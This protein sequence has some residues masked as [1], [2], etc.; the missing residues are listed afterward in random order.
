M[1]GTHFWYPESTQGTWYNQFGM[2]SI[3]K[4]SLS[5]N[6]SP[7]VPKPP[8]KCFKKVGKTVRPIGA[9]KAIYYNPKLDFGKKNYSSPKFGSLFPSK[10]RVKVVHEI[11]GPGTYQLMNDGHWGKDSPRFSI[12]MSERP[13]Y[14]KNVQQRAEESPDP[15]FHFQDME[16]KTSV[17]HYRSSFPKL[18]EPCLGPGPGHYLNGEAKARTD[19]I[20]PPSLEDKGMSFSRSPRFKGRTRMHKTSAQLRLEKEKCDYVQNNLENV[21]TKADK[22]E[23]IRKNSSARE[24]KLS[25]AEQNR[26][27]K[28]KQHAER[29][30]E[31]ATKHVAALNRRRISFALRILTIGS[32]QTFLMK[33]L[34]KT[35][36]ENFNRKLRIAELYWEKK[37]FVRWAA[38]Y[39]SSKAHRMA[40]RV[41][42]ALRRHTVKARIKRK[43]AAAN[44][45]R[46]VLHSEHGV[47]TAM[48]QIKVFKYNTLK[49]QRFIKKCKIATDGRVE[50]L[51]R[52]VFK[53]VV[54]SVVELEQK[55]SLLEGEKRGK[56][57]GDPMQ[58]AL[59]RQRM[60]DV[61]KPQLYELAKHYQR[62][63]WVKFK[64]KFVKRY[65]QWKGLQ[66]R[67]N[68]E[69]DG[70]TR[71]RLKEDLDEF[72]L[73]HY[74]WLAPDSIMKEMSYHAISQWRELSSQK[75][76]AVTKEEEEKGN[77]K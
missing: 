26:T 31:L 39:K 23:Q 10:A 68:M 57:K 25:L 3:N 6:Q 4:V 64:S 12:G 46:R 11:P 52:Q 72:T 47:D 48:R 30:L 60:L 13:N 24:R 54:S 29:S 44:V 67:Y 33:K 36:E 43:R 76:A 45:I 73:P 27:Q 50:I 14:F 8:P 59:Q 53:Y 63:S 5:N 34:T 77:G 40:I 17:V 65:S 61:L 70:E 37:M 2:G 62:V 28:S 19:A 35:R 69:F 56:K 18:K 32:R 51:F 20:V 38:A 7:I 15:K 22:D 75:Q 55:E 71:K 66:D 1:P 49:V 21:Q 42:C 41:T 16:F 58:M 74:S 9:I